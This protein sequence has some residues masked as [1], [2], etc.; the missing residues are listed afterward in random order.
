MRSLA[1]RYPAACYFTFA[2]AISCGSILVVVGGGPIPAPPDEAHRLFALVYLGMLAGPSVAG[3]AMTASVRGLAGLRDCR[4]RL[5]AWR[6]APIWYAVA[7]LTAPLALALTALVLSQFSGDFVPATIGS[8]GAIDPAGPIQAGN[9]KTLLLLAVAVGAGAGFFEE[10]GWTGFAVPTLLKRHSALSTGVIVGI[11]W[12]A[13][14]F[15]AVWF[16]GRM[17]FPRG[18]VG[19][20]ERVRVGARP[21]LSSRRALHVPAAV[22][23]VNGASVQANGKPAARHPHA[24][25]SYREHDHLRGSYQRRC[26]GRVQSRVRDDAVSDRRP[27]AGLRSHAI[28]EAC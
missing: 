22:P 6:V 23:R 14:H 13:W 12:G 19:Q 25:E 17:A 2:F 26:V 11:F 18:M 28:P 3:L 16:L 9:V 1:R 4:A 5:L 10:L 27:N 7:L 15:P 20:R 24:W 8:T 21:A